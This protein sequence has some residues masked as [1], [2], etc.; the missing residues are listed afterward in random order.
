MQLLPGKPR[1]FLLQLIDSFGCLGFREALVE[2]FA[3]VSRQRLE[4]RALRGRHRLVA[5]LPIVGVFLE[6]RF[7]GLGV[8]VHETNEKQNKRQR[9]KV[10]PIHPLRDEAGPGPVDLLV[11]GVA[12]AG[13]WG[14]LSHRAGALAL[15]IGWQPVRLPR[16]RPWIRGGYD[17]STGDA[18]PADDRHGNPHVAF[19][20]YYAYAAVAR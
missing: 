13:S 7:W 4:I 5:G 9:I 2:H 16:L 15:E 19:G 18:D 12:Q 17:Y 6:S 8:L 14:T 1:R 11:W 10:E 20:L 3:A